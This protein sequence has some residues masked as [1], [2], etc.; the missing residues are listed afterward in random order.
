M[1]Y[2]GFFVLE[3]RG[4]IYPNAMVTGKRFTTA[5]TGG[6]KTGIMN[7]LF[8][9]LLQILDEKALID[10]DIIALDDSNIRAL[11]AAA[12]AKKTSR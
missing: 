6:Q 11:K 9:N 5:L 8:N 3:H 4:G 7:S 1:A 2:F 12:G 10:W